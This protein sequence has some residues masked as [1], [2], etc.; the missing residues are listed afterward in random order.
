L[1]ISFFDT[2]VGTDLLQRLND[3][4]KIRDFLTY[5]LN[6]IMVMALNLLVYSSVLLYYDVRVFFIF[7]FFTVL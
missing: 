3:E 4:S 2:K 6:N 7:L 5:M 1:P